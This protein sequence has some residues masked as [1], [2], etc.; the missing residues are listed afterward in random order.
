MKKIFSF[1]LLLIF[2][3]M[4]IKPYVP[5]IDYILNKEYIAENLCE[6]KD[7]P[8][9][10]CH[11]QCHLKK[12]VEKVSE[13]EKETSDLPYSNPKEENKQQINLFV[14]LADEIILKVKKEPTYFSYQDMESSFFQRFIIPPP[15]PAVTYQAGLCE[16]V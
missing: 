12:E 8:K 7:K 14:E 13:Q 2:M 4:Y 11:G 15:K 6:N 5:Y 9:L 10:N 16:L 1:G 3:L